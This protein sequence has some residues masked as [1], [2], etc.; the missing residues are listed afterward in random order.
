MNLLRQSC[1]QIV[2]KITNK[3]YTSYVNSALITLV[4]M[5]NK[6]VIGG[7][8][9][10]WFQAESEAMLGRGVQPKLRKHEHE[11]SFHCC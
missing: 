11:I 3:L 10:Q 2:K 9:E 5:I 7:C 1:S 4:T 8:L 6:D